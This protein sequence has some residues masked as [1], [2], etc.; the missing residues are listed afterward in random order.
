MTSTA[1]GAA[2]VTEEQQGLLLPAATGDCEVH[3][4]MKRS[5]RGKVW[6]LK[7]TEGSLLLAEC[8]WAWHRL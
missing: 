5:C 4:T 3:P 6:R 1:H 8:T 2:T 7:R